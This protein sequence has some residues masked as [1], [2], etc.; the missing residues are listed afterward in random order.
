MSRSHCIR[1]I[2]NLLLFIIRYGLLCAL[3]ELILHELNNSKAH[4]EANLKEFLLKSLEDKHEC[5]IRVIAGEILGL[6]CNTNAYYNEIEECLLN[7]IC[8]YINGDLKRRKAKKIYKTLFNKLNPNATDSDSDSASSGSDIEI[9]GIEAREF[10]LDVDS[11]I[12]LFNLND[13]EDNIDAALSNVNNDNNNTGNED[14]NLIDFECEHN[15]ESVKI[16]R[17]LQINVSFN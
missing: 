2:V 6:L 13:L 9:T 12:E 14:D 3:K 17:K 7:L 8:K 11:D 4:N 15:K 16:I 1:S 10:G 5:R